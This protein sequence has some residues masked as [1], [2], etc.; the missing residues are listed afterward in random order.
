MAQAP[1]TLLVVEAN[2][3]GTEHCFF[4]AAMLSALIEATARTEH[5]VILFADR[6]H[7]EALVSILPAVAALPWTDIPVVSGVRRS[8]FKKFFV[9]ARV[10]L[11]A[12]RLARSKNARVLVLSTFANMLSFLLLLRPVFRRVDL[13]VVL[14]CEV[15]SLIIRE[16][17]G[18]HREG[19]WTRLALFHLF[20]GGW[21]TF[22]VLGEGIRARLLQRFPERRLLEQVRSIEHPYLFGPC[23]QRS[24]PGHRAL[25]VGFVGSG[26]T[27]KGIDDFF[28]LA[29]SL[30]AYVEAGRVEF[31]VVGGLENDSPRFDRKW[32]RVLA[33]QPGGLGVNEFLRAVASLDCAVFLYRQNY[34]FTASGAVFDVINAGVSILSLHNH[35]LSDLACGDAEG[36]IRFFASVDAVAD[37]IRNWL[38]RGSRPG[39]FSYK[40]IRD[41]HSG[42]VRTVIG[43]EILG[44][45]VI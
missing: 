16:K 40:G 9:E 17:R 39:T 32:V 25:R 38:E 3:S 31:V 10:L 13:H 44:K 36:G 28:R 26:R 22:Y 2:K 8:F 6:A 21:P 43:R 23:P 20:R 45:P 30:S 11:K 33:E 41:S 34:A 27:V 12:L 5:E 7:R 19:F 35:Y 29:E 15:E 37:E 14:H 24:S 4:N 42:G 18:I 1:T